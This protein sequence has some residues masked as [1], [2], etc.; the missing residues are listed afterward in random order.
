M[1]VCLIAVPAYSTLGFF[2]DP[3][4]DPMLAGGEGRVVETVIHELV[5]ATVFVKS[6]P[7]FNEGAATFIGEE[8]S[9]RFY[10]DDADAAARR[11]AE[12]DDGR[13]LAREEMALRD[14]IEALYARALPDDQRDDARATLEAEARTKLAALPLTTRDPA[15][16]AQH[17]RLGD[18]CLALSGA[19]VADGP[20]HAAVLRALDGD[21]V[22]FIDRLRAVADDDDPRA[23]FFAS[24]SAPVAAPAT[25]PAT[26][27]PAA[28]AVLAPTASVRD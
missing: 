9:I 12:V 17:M 16:L 1:D 18:A 22:R 10:A 11:R 2:D 14:A 23:A 8:A 24:A 4:T 26:A 15:W 3:L 27:T 19:Y 28:A 25:A 21:L 20:R 7:E 13:I 6:Q 5:H